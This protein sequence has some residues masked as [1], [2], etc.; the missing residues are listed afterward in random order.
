MR[1]STGVHGTL[2]GLALDLTTQA[3]APFA[4]LLRRSG[5]GGTADEIAAGSAN[6]WT[7]T[8]DQ[9][10]GG[11]GQLDSGA[12]AIAVPAFSMPE[13]VGRLRADASARAELAAERVE[14]VNWWLARMV[15][16][17]NPLQEKLTF[18]L[19]G[20]F[21]TAISKVRYPVFMYRQ[22][23]LFRSHG[24]GPF[25]DLTQQVAVDPAMLIWLDAS[26]DKAQ[27]PNENFARELMERFTMGIGTYTEADVRAAAYCFTGWQLNLRTGA[28]SISALDHS[29]APQTFLGHTG[30]N[31]G[32]QVIDIVTTTNAS[33]HYIPSV[34][35]S[36]LAAPVTPTSAVASELA[37]GYASG[38]NVGDLLRAIVTHPGFLT[39]ETQGGLIKQPVEYVVGA[40]RALGVT[41]AE[42]QA[43]PEGV[44]ATLAGL[45]QIP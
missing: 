42:F 23:Q 45:G 12:D 10:V 16:T 18:L 9:L 44:L 27:D 26:S 28:F 22:N 30:I 40:L 37:P 25:P 17:T 7:A 14:L 29:D 3:S 38:R 19:H 36:R 5:F 2:G 39:T 41:A 31:S 1:T 43:R 15:A 13:D 24:S 21:A 34:F 4:Q 11:L 35:W 6:G 33:S 20:L 8:V 32:T